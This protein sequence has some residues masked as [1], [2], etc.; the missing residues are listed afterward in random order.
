MAKVQTNS[1]LAVR[2]AAFGVLAVGATA[3]GTLAIGWITIRK[4]RVFGRQ[5][6]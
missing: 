4:L 6:R 1:A 2:A 5:V 3:I